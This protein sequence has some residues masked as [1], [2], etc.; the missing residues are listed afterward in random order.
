M[1]ASPPRPERPA[2]ETELLLARYASEKRLRQGRAL[3]YQGDEADAV[4]RLR[5]GRIRPIRVHGEEATALDELGPGDWLGLAEVY[6]GLPWL[7]DA[8]ALEDC[9]L[10]RYSRYN[11]FE[12]LKGASFRDLVLD[13]LARQHYLIHGRIGPGGAAGK[14]AQA[15][16]SA[17]RRAGGARQKDGGRPAG[18]EKGAGTIVIATTQAGL[19]EATG[20]A[21]ETVNRILGSLEAKGYIETGRGEILVYDLEG[22]RAWIEG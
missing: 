17:A 9:E 21:R 1:P 5:R 8:L 11:F 10:E 15:I 12:L 13:L 6:L 22:L 20:L 3:H 18:E 19:A 16:L 4:Y 14:V 7:T 2:P